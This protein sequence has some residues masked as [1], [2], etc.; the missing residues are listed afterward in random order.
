MKIK[1]KNTYFLPK[2][3]GLIF[4]KILYYRVIFQ[5]KNKDKNLL[6]EIFDFNNLDLAINFCKNIENYQ[7]INITAVVEQ[8]GFYLEDPK[9]NVIENKSK[10]R[11]KYIDKKRI[12]EFSINLLKKKYD[13]SLY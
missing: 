11:Y 5:Y 6:P 9:G 3:T 7:F 8:N 4:H 10:I 13:I 2:N 12:A 1:N